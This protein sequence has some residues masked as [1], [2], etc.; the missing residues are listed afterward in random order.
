V[1]RTGNSFTPEVTDPRPA[2]LFYGT[3]AHVC[4]IYIHTRTHAA[5]TR[6][7]NYISPLFCEKGDNPQNID[8]IGGAE[9]TCLK[10]LSSLLQ[11][12]YLSCQNI[13]IVILIAQIFDVQ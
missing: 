7:Q 11:T 3:S 10:K 9:I 1:E 12:N 6:A 2:R 13:M 5:G 4:N 8:F